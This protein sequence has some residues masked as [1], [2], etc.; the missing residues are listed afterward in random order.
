MV[1]TPGLL[2]VRPWPRRPIFFFSFLPILFEDDSPANFE[3]E[4]LLQHPKPNPPNVPQELLPWCLPATAT[5]FLRGLSL[6]YKASHFLKEFYSGKVSQCEILSRS[7]ACFLQLAAW[8]ALDH[9]QVSLT[10]VGEMASIPH[11]SW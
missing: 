5:S 1:R 7:K 6:K 10:T 2:V 4:A 9:T 3:M 8:R 11:H